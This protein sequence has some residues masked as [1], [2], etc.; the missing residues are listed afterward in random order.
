M[1]LLPE[2]ISYKYLQYIVSTNLD[3]NWEDILD[4]NQ[5]SFEQKCPTICFL[6]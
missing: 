6:L 4:K 2:I 1:M 5:F 3:M